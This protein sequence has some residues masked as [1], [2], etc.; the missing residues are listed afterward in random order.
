M[1]RIVFLP[2][3]C[4]CTIAALAQAPVQK[5]VEQRAKDKANS[6]V[7][8]SIDRGLDSAFDNAGRAIGSIFKKKDKRKAQ[9]APSSGQDNPGTGKGA[10][11]GTVT[12]SGGSDFVP[13]AKVLFED[14]FDKDGLGDFPAQW[15]T[16]GSGKVVTLSGQG[17]RWL[18]VVHNC[19]VVP[20]VKGPLPENCTI[21][22]DLFLR[23]E[24]GRS[25]PFI[26]FGLSQVKDI[27]KED[28]FYKDRFFINLHR[29][30]EEDGKT[31]EYGLGND[32]IGNKSNFPLT[33]YVNKVL[34]VAIA[35][36]KSRIRL[37]L[38]GNK[39]IDLPRALTDGMRNTFFL[40]NNAIIPASETG[41]YVGN[42]R[43]ASGDTDARSLLVKQLM[44][45]GKAVTSDILFDVNSDHLKPESFPIIDQFGDA[46]QK[47]PAL[48]IR[49]IGH[50]D[51]NGDDASNISLS[52]RRAA[53][54]KT[55]I[56]E[57]YAVAGS[58]IQTDGKGES[59]PVA[60]NTTADGKAR[61][62]RVEFVKL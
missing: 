14:H 62:R 52:Q 7:D 30:T 53:A 16:N 41:M 31:L 13:G 2:I 5:R 40:N 36:N 9:P 42:L 24:S 51:S 19:I 59:Q 8:A 26:Q 48:R 11:S 39:V 49:I 1:K 38:D 47:T 29:Y 61:N 56:T 22:F 15:N 43:I 58:R 46:L 17:S 27:L 34:P 18:D 32:I 45:E 10:A 23:S 54:V 60:S 37:Y 12:S 6:R 4:I 44:S 21:E 50:T 33:S 28:M 25:T 20:V 35:V 55:Y 3:L 57:N